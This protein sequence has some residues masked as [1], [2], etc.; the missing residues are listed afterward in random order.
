MRQHNG[1]ETELIT[2]NENKFDQHNM[3]SQSAAWHHGD[4]GSC[5]RLRNRLDFA[6][7]RRNGK[8]D[9]QDLQVQKDEYI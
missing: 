5:E 9:L 6:V 1:F 4:S 7:F 3:T 2:C 8:Q